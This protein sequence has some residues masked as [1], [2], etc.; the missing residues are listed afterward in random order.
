M[1]KSPLTKS[2]GAG[3]PGSTYES[4]SLTLISTI[5]AVPN[6]LFATSHFASNFYELAEYG[7]ES[8]L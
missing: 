5:L 4:K 3:A 8:F 6:E 7:V 2:P 1:S